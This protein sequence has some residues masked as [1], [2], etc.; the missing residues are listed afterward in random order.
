M[1]A[2]APAGFGLT[3]WLKPTDVL[4]AKVASPL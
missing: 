2:S 3:A 1:P 4:V